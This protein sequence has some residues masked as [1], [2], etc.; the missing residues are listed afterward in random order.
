MANNEDPFSEALQLKKASKLN[1][2]FQTSKLHISNKY[3]KVGRGFQYTPTVYGKFLV[4]QEPENGPSC[5]I[6][7][8]GIFANTDFICQAKVILTLETLKIKMIEIF[9]F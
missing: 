9:S 3:F 5:L 4:F 2:N 8:S 6:S 7:I 1:S